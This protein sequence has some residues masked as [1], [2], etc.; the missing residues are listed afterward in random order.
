MAKVLVVD[1]EPGMRL[2]LA[3]FLRGDGH[4]ASTAEDVDAAMRLIDAGGID[5]VVSDIIMPGKSGVELLELSHARDPGIGVILLTGEPNVETASAAVRKGAFDYLAKPV[6]KSA[7]LAVVARAARAKEQHDANVRLTREN[8]RY[9]TRLEELVDTRTS[10]L[11]AA[12]RGTIGVVAQTLEIRDPYTAGHQRR[13]ASLSL[14]V[15]R[16][17]SLPDVT[18]EGIEMAALVH[19]IGK[20]A[21]PADI[22]SKPGSLTTHEFALIQQHPRTGY[23]ILRKVDFPWPVAEVICQHHER[24]DG[25]GYPDGLS[26]DAIRIES[27][28]I[29]VADVVEA[30]ASHRPYRPALGIDLALEEIRRHRGTVYDAGVVDACQRLL[31]SD[32]RFDA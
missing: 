6:S 2:S 4:E 27:R 12:L 5:V 21:V 25:S 18:Q 13:V 32:F 22:L 7:V 17:L 26:G 9:R 3:T 14:S 19:D 28:I 29:S 24:L 31:E 15:A 20:I 11:A 30:M 16:A 1:D 10:Q 23:N 8:E